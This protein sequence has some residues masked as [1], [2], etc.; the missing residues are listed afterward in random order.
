MAES[1]S[2]SCPA[3]G[4]LVP[5]AS[6]CDLCG[7]ELSDTAT[8]MEPETI[9]RVDEILEE[10]TR[11]P[12]VAPALS[13][14]PFLAA[15]SSGADEDL[16]LEIDEM[17][18]FITGVHSSFGFRLAG[19]AVEAAAV[20]DLEIELK[21]HGQPD[22][23]K[24]KRR[25]LPRGEWNIPFRSMEPG[26]KIP[27]EVMF[28]CHLDGQL[29]RYEGDFLFDCYPPEEPPGKIIENLVVKADDN[30]SEYAATQNISV[31][32]MENFTGQSAA[33]LPQQ[34]KM[35]KVDPV[36]RR[37]PWHRCY[38]SDLEEA[39]L[40]A[41]PGLTDPPPPVDRLTLFSLHKRM[42]FFSGSCITLGRSAS[43]SDIP[44]RIYLRDGRQDRALSG[45]ISRAHARIMIEPH[46]VWIA[47]GGYSQESRTVKESACGTRLN[48]RP[49]RFN[50][51]REL[52][53]GSSFRLELADFALR[54]VVHTLDSL[55]DCGHQ[56]S[57]DNRTGPAAIVLEREDGRPDTYCILVRAFA[58]RQLDATSFRREWV[59]CHQDGFALAAPQGARMGACWMY[60][61]QPR[62]AGLPPGWNIGPFA[63]SDPLSAK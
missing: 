18:V 3:C 11:P 47:D 59:V 44:C 19:R 31:R 34:M 53:V 50:Q 36:W 30:R 48:D 1:S 39:C 51:P 16:T 42:H 56:Q 6:F 32:V 55:G 2:I 57:H 23:V 15:A 63:Y 41:L 14:T 5:A 4:V 9:A 40:H 24:E 20:H 52:P 54:G 33:S 26:L 49:V 29:H 46:K 60:P 17:R 38:G 28:S 45:K 22:P 12:E 10:Q 13:Q 8:R 25:N 37:V 27:V 58:L 35:L 43:H 7:T 61:Q 62:C 21:I